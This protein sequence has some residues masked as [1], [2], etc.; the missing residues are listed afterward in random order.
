MT[1]T[2]AANRVEASATIL[3]CYLDPFRDCSEKIDSI[4]LSLSVALVVLLTVGGGIL[5]LYL[6][7]IL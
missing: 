3:P 1:L 6:N 4:L 5:Y 7:F 2:T